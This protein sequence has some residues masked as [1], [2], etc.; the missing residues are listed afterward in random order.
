MAAPEL[1]STIPALFRIE[2]INKEAIAELEKAKAAA[3]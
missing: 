2:G 3:G 1:A